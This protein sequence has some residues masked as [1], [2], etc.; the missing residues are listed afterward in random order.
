M[1]FLVLGVLFFVILAVMFVFHGSG[2]STPDITEL[3]PGEV[4]V[5]A[6]AMGE[7]LATGKKVGTAL[8]RLAILLS[9]VMQVL[10]WIMAARKLKEVKEMPVSSQ[11]LHLDAIDVY[12]DLP[13]YFG[14]LGTVLSFVLITVY[15]DAGL[16]FAY[17][18]TAFGI[19]VSTILRLGYLTPYRQELIGQG[20]AAGRPRNRGRTGNETEQAI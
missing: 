12:F 9:L 7:A 18:S 20:F 13:L 16:M 15:P 1:F 11:P 19:I 5:T 8:A 10:A 14:L 4:M 3:V 6:K 2:G 17:T